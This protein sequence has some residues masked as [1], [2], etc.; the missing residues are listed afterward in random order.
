LGHFWTTLYMALYDTISC[1]GLI[2]WFID[3][4]LIKGLIMIIMWTDCRWKAGQLRARRSVRT[5]DSRTASGHSVLPLTLRLEALSELH[6]RDEVLALVRWTA[7]L[8]ARP[9]ILCAYLRE[10]GRHRYQLHERHL[11]RD[12]DVL[13]LWSWPLT[14]QLWT[15]LSTH[16]TWWNVRLRL[17]IF[18]W[19]QSHFAVYATGVILFA[20]FVSLYCN[21]HYGCE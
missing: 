13:H 11:L 1:S 3:S 16:I 2:Y 5:L 15:F 20:C 10:I 19:F 12:R 8:L 9:G 6:G 17:L 7:E 14:F 18:T 4:W 21:S